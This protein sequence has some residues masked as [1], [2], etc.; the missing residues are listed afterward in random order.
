M[1][2]KPKRNQEDGHLKN[3]MHELDLKELAKESLLLFFKR[4]SWFVGGEVPE[5]ELL[6]EESIN[7]VLFT[8][9]GDEPFAFIHEKC[10]PCVR[11]PK[12]Y[13]ETSL[14]YTVSFLLELLAEMRSMSIP[15]EFQP[16]LVLLYFKF[17]KGI[18]VPLFTKS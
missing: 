5:K 9:F 4:K 6:S 18:N 17:C 15:K 3:G 13:T 14:P 7:A 16:G 1:P 2:R 8:P 11:Q 10:L 12:S